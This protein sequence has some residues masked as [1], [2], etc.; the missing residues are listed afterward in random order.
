MLEIED[1]DGRERAALAMVGNDAIWAFRPA[2]FAALGYPASIRD[3][4]ELV[5]FVDPMKEDL[6]RALTQKDEF[7]RNHSLRTRFTR[8]EVDIL[9]ALRLRVGTLSQE[10][11]GRRILPINSLIGALGLFRVLQELAQGRKLTIMEIGPG[12]GYLGAL[13]IE[14]GHRY[15]ALEN[16]QGFYLWQN[17]LF[18]AVASTDFTDWVK[19]RSISRVIHVP[20]WEFVRNGRDFPLSVDLAI[21]DHMLCEMHPLA[22][23]YVLSLLATVLARSPLAALIFSGFGHPH[24][25]REDVE[26]C[27]SAFGFSQIVKENLY[28]YTLKER[29]VQR[30]LLS[31]A[32]T[33]PLYL[34]S[35]ERLLSAPEFMKLSW[36]E[37]PYDYPFRKQMGIWNNGK[38]FVSDW[39]D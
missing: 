8:G 15:A 2:A 27:L 10:W 9:T 38:L 29:P 22:L 31:L 33:V 19:D 12:A 23:R 34:D 4:A 16:A 25:S 30:V 14:A 36:D 21:C 26:T 3:P 6:G 39:R 18:A 13:L 37:L 11:F 17:R 20:W 32:K 24:N 28:A 5:R 1:Y 7:L 35:G